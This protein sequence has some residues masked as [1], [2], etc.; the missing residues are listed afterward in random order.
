MNNNYWKRVVVLFC[1]GWVV[2]WIYRGILSPISDTIQQTFSITETQFGLIASVFFFGYVFMQIPSG[3]LA[4]KFGRKRILVIGFSIFSLG[5][6]IVGLAKSYNVLIFGSFL[7]GFGEGTYFGTAYSISAVAVPSDKKTMA[8]ALI[9]TG[10]AVGIVIAFIASNYL[11]GVLGI[12]WRILVLATFVS[13]FLM[14]VIFATF[15]KSDKET[16]DFD[17]KE[18]IAL[19]D[20]LNKKL[21]LMGITYFTVCYAYYMLITWLPKF[22]GS[23]RGFPIE[24]LG[25]AASAVA[26]AG[27]PGALIISR[28]VD[29]LKVNKINIIIG[30]NILSSIVLFLAVKVSSPTLLMIC[31]A[32][33]GFFGKLAVDPIIISFVTSFSNKRVLGISVAIFNFC[34]MSSSIFAPVITG[35]ISDNTGSKVIGFYLA[36]ILLLVGVVMLFTLKNKVFKFENN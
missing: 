18:K 24:I 1:S 29:K 13:V 25:Y 14:T 30:L 15:I 21:I 5:A 8:S 34:G 20:I 33:Y 7:A 17:S 3:F 31:L 23:E 35:A 9:N 22:L 12:N 16:Q 11:V 26:L 4:D 28:F 19:K 2:A 32:I 27:I 36:S 10:T 6:L